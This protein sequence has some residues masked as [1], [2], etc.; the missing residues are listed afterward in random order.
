MPN[1]GNIRCKGTIE[2]IRDTFKVPRKGQSGDQLRSRA[3]MV[4]KGLERLAEG[5]PLK[6]L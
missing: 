2:E 3:S 4:R 5:R 1:R 6:A